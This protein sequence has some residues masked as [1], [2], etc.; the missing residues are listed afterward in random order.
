MKKAKNILTIILILVLLFSATSC[1]KKNLAVDTAV[2]ESTE[3]AINSVSEVS[4][5]NEKA[6]E[7]TDFLSETT[8]LITETEPESVT[9]REKPVYSAP[10]VTTVLFAE[11]SASVIGAAPESTTIPE[12]TT[13]SAPRQ[14]TTDKT[15]SA[16][17][18]EPKTTVTSSV[19]EPSTAQ[20]Q[21]TAPVSNTQTVKVKVNCRHAVEYGITNVPQNG[22]I[23]DTEVVYCSGDTAMDVLKRALESDNIEIDENRGYVRGIAG[24]SEKDCGGSSGWMYMVNSESPMIAS[25]KYSVAPGDTVTFYYVTNY[26]D[27]V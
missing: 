17:K 10:T 22:I 11:T 4:A 14:I 2:T 7:K 5:E 25:D 21:T 12:R 6:A 23:L 9:V 13:S 1:A 19:T 24:L 20:A 16:A 26:G 3:A 18:S 8:A 27:S 15:T